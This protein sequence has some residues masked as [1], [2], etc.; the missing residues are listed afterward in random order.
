MLIFEKL[1]RTSPDKD[2]RKART[3][4]T[5]GF[6]AEA[7]IFILCYFLWYAGKPLVAFHFFDDSQEWQGIDK[8][9]HF[10]F[11]F[12]ATLIFGFWLRIAGEEVKKAS[13]AAFIL[14]LMVLLPIEVF[15]GF[16]QGWGFS[17]ADLTAN[18]AGCL[19]AFTILR[20]EN[21]PW[22]LPK[23]SFH[24]SPLAFL[25][26]ELMGGNWFFRALKDYNG[27]TYWLSFSP[28]RILGR[29]IFP[30]WLLLS[31]GYG[32]D[33]MAGGYENTFRNKQGEWIDLR[34]V[35]RYPQFYI[36]FDIDFARLFENRLQGRRL[37][38]V[39]HALYFLNFFKI[40]APAIEINAGQGIRL[41]WLYW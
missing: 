12:H 3:Y 28:N 21:T 33:G 38:Y 22:M 7:L 4:L 20:R 19:L 25:R 35:L 41:W 1:W 23:F 37:R 40:P 8:C 13:M 39:Q 10:Y 36:S 2:S 31:I 34:E 5:I 32:A 29:K 6:I 24:L 14:G 17:P 15:D 18:V 16:A 9:G 27:Q 26:P 30:S 11:S